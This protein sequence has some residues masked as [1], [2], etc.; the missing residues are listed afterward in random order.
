MAPLSLNDPRLHTVSELTMPLPGAGGF[1]VAPPS[2]DLKT[3]PLATPASIG[4]PGRR[5]VKTA[6]TARLSFFGFF[7]SSSAPCASG[8]Q[9]PPTFL[10]SPADVPAYVVTPLVNTV[11]TSFAPG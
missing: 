5:P 8:C 4:L 2:V 10:N 6:W 3:P 9:P 11:R 1:H 7:G